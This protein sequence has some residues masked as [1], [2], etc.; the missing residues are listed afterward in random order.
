MLCAGGIEGVDSC[1][2]DSGG[3][4]GMQL[5]LKQRINVLVCH[6]NGKYT[7]YGVVS[8]GYGCGAAMPGVYADAFALRK[9]IKA[10]L[11]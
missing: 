2:G 1:T 10:N 9:W 8:F 4:L 11:Q 3:P 7:L 5:G 6:A